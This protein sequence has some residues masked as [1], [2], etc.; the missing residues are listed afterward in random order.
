MVKT[1]QITRDKNINRDNAPNK[2]SEDSLDEQLK[3]DTGTD[4]DIENFSSV[5]KPDL[6]NH[7][8]EKAFL[9]WEAESLRI[10]KICLEQK[11]HEL[12]T[13][14]DD[15]A[16]YYPSASVLLGKSPLMKPSV[17]HGLKSKLFKK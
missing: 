14:I 11:N 4:Q 7:E 13:R 6:S 2:D 1:I 12:Q 9:E 3:N 17:W 16:K 5:M 15:L 8:K 10:D